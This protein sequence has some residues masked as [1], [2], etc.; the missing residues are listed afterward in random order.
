MPLHIYSD[1]VT[2]YIY[3][4]QKNATVRLIKIHSRI[5][6]HLQKRLYAM[7]KAITCFLAASNNVTAGC[8]DFA[9]N[10][11]DLAGEAKSPNI[12]EILL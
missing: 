7:T 2:K 11:Y 3:S 6:L 9:I 1:L 12:N 10:L 5:R 4:Q 8:I